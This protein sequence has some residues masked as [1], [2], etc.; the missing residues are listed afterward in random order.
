MGF[1]PKQVELLSF[2]EMSILLSTCLV[3][4]VL[5][6]KF[7]VNSRPLETLLLLAT[8]LNQRASLFSEL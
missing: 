7:K 1:L 8:F 2:Q 5:N 6:V 4:V 3:P